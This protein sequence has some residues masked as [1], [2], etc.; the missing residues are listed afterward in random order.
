MKSLAMFVLE[1]TKYEHCGLE[2]LYFFVSFVAVAS[3]KKTV[4]TL[5]RVSTSLEEYVFLTFFLLLS[6]GLSMSPE[7]VRECMSEYDVDNGQW[8]IMCIYSHCVP[9]LYYLILL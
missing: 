8:Y 2:L 7:Q 9:Y 3:Y 4:I 5:F 1:L 6:P